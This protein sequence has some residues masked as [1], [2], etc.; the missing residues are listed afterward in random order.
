VSARRV[1][2]TL[3]TQVKIGS[4]AEVAIVDRT[5]D[6]DL[7]EKARDANSIVRLQNQDSPSARNSMIESPL[8]AAIDIAKIDIIGRRD[9]RRRKN[10][11]R[12]LRSNL[13]R[14]RLR[15][16]MSSNKSNP[17]PL[18]IRF[19]HWPGCFWR[20]RRVMTFN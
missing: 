15:S 6:A 8:A 14:A 1:N 20:K 10:H 9:V 11:C 5:I 19:L 12:R 17:A 7:I 3:S 13:S 18:R 4:N 2:V 16:K